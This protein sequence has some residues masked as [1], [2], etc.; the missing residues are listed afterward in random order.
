MGVKL[1]IGMICIPNGIPIG[2]WNAK[3]R[4]AIPLSTD[5]LVGVR[6][7][8]RQL[9]QMG[10]A[11]DFHTGASAYRQAFAGQLDFSMRHLRQ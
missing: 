4:T 3:N 1:A 7:F 8:L 9:K 10:Q 11:K 2:N 5:K 6:E